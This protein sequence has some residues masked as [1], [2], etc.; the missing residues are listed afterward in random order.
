M[1]MFQKGLVAGALIAASVSAFAET[2]VENGDV[3]GQAECSLLG[4]NVRVSLSSDVVAAYECV[5]VTSAINIATCHTAGQRAA[6]TIDCAALGEDANGDTVYND[7]SCETAGVTSFDVELSYTGYAASS[8]GG[9]VGQAPLTGI[10]N[11][12]NLANVTIFAD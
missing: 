5:E 8:L 6:R 4:E 12:A 3:L 9:S 10:C 7:A 2:A 11:D 1:K